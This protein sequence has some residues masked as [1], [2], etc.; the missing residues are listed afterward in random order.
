MCVS[1]KLD[2]KGRTAS[3]G[4][5]ATMAIYSYMELKVVK[6]KEKDHVCVCVISGTGMVS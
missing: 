5:S 6:S 4:G 3:L 1:P 2:P